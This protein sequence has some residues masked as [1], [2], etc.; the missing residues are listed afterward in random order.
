MKSAKNVNNNENQNT[1]TSKSTKETFNSPMENPPKKQTLEDLIKDNGDL[2]NS[3]RGLVTDIKR[4]ESNKYENLSEF[5]RSF[6]NNYM[7]YIVSSPLSTDP[8]SL[9]F[10]KGLNQMLNSPENTNKRRDYIQK[11]IDYISIPLSA[12]YNKIAPLLT[13]DHYHN[14]AT[15]SMND[16]MIMLNPFIQNMKNELSKNEGFD[17][18]LKLNQLGKDILEDY[19][20]GDFSKLGEY[21][22]RIPYNKEPF[23]KSGLTEQQIQDMI[24]KQDALFGEM[25]KNLKDESKKQLMGLLAMIANSESSK[26]VKNLDKNYSMNAIKAANPDPITGLYLALNAGNYANQADKMAMALGPQMDGSEEMG[27]YI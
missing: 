27:G 19:K 5:S 14:M 6:V 23:L 2:Y 11:I 8:K 22:E 25:S 21:F 20:K 1:D 16:P 26:Q 4:F 10:A 18:S 15:G 9:A 7:N 3:I 12:E 17:R 24:K 13:A